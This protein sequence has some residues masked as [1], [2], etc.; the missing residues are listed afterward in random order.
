MSDDAAVPDDDLEAMFA[1]AVPDDIEYMFAQTSSG[2]SV[3]SEGRVTLNGVSSTTLF[4]SD[5]PERVAGHVPTSAVI[6]SWSVGG[7]D[8]FEADPPNA[9]LSILVGY[10][11]QEIVVVLE[12]P[13]YSGD[14]LTFELRQPVPA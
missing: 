3:G 4:F 11:P 1:D 12:K 5:R 9:T 6:D 2:V 10:Q 7:D 14:D 13:V 8:S